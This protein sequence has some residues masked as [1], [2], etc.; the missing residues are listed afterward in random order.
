MVTT[1]RVVGSDAP[2]VARAAYRTRNPAVASH[3]AGRLF[4][5]HRLRVLEDPA[6]FDARA[7]VADLRDVRVNY[8]SFGAGVQ[9]DRPATDTYVGVLIPI[10]GR[11]GVEY[12]GTSFTAGPA[13][14]NA[15]LM[16]SGP[17]RLTWSG[18]CR[19]LSFYIASGRLGRQVA[20]MAPAIDTGPLTFSTGPLSGNPA[21]T[22]LGLAWLVTD[23][24]DRCGP[25]E[26]PPVPVLTQ[27]RD[28][29]LTTLLLSVP[30]SHS[31]ALLLR[32]PVLGRRPV[33][34]AVK[35]IEAE[36]DGGELTVSELAQGVGV[37]LRSLEIAFRRDLDT[38]PAQYLR[39][40]RLRRARQELLTAEP[41]SGLR[42]QDVAQRWGFFHTG[43]FSRLYRERFGEYPSVTILSGAATP[44]SR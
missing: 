29:V 7:H 16:G 39:D 36:T 5:R 11:L 35:L 30:H 42:V 23:T 28:A 14:R 2:L 37:G 6:R 33:A 24:F 20:R 10:A 18:D 8:V 12:D 3:E 31:R 34:A 19:V 43:R 25:Q 32:E 38:T 44:P 9:I 27:L 15:V 17:I 40:V 13:G 4:A 26:A 41:S 21:A 1:D 22:L